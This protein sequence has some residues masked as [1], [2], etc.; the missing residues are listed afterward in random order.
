MSTLAI[1]PFTVT[2]HNLQPLTGANRYVAHFPATDL[3]FPVRS[4]WSMT[5]YDSHGFFVP[6]AAH[7]YL[8]NNRSSVHYNPDG[9][10]D[11]YIQHARP[12][13]ALAAPQ[14]APVALVSG[15]PTDHAPVQAGRR[16]RNPQRPQLA[17]AHRAAMPR[18]Q[19]RG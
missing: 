18:R 17:A 2:D 8:I 14:L 16:R 15:I 12:S 9:S 6:N 7:V 19:R 11:I 10:L 5:L 4:F 3:P 13:S 1:Y